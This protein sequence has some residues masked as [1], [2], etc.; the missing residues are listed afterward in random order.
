MKA[1]KFRLYPTDEQKVIINKTFGCTRKIY[2]YFLNK[3]QE[4]Y[5][6]NKTNISAYDCCKEIKELIKEYP[7]LKEVD[8]CAL[9]C[10]IFDLDNAYNRFFKEQNNY[11]NFKNKFGKNSYRTNNISNTYKDKNY[12]SIELDLVKKNVKL[13]KLKEV[14]I[15]GYR[16]KIKQEGRIVNATISREADNRYYVSILIEEDIKIKQVEKEEIVGIDLGI[17][18]L[19]TTSDNETY[20]NPKALIKY[21]KKLKHMQKELSRKEKGSNNYYKCK[22]KIAVIHRKIRNTRKHYLHGISKKITDTKTIIVTETLKI[23]NMLKTTN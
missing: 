12:N 3:K 9:R 16:N 18:N 13:P 20:K 10:S 23:K 15:K 1:Y 14:K 17:K 6:L 8:S 19:V 4:Q 21:E 2:N 22:E 11:P 5:K 7:Y